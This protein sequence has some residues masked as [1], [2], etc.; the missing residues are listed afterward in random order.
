MGLVLRGDAERRG[1]D[2]SGAG[3]RLVRDAGAPSSSAAASASA[4]ASRSA[5]T[6]C[7]AFTTPR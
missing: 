2:P 3:A 4:C 5:T 1:V 6:S 7:T